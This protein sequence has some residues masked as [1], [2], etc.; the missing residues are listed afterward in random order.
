[1][2]RLLIS[3]GDRQFQ[4]IS[5]A[6]FATI[7]G[8][9][10]FD[11]VEIFCSDGAQS[12][13]LKT[14]WIRKLFFPLAVKFSG[15][16]LIFRCY[17]SRKLHFRS[18]FSDHLELLHYIANELLLIFN[19]AIA[20]KFRI[21]FYSDND[22]NVASNFIASILKMEKIKRSAKVE[23]EF[24]CL[25]KVKIPLEAITNWLVNSEEN[26]NK[27][28]HSE[29]FFEVKVGFREVKF[30]RIHVSFRFDRAE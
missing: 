5:N 10:R 21:H 26:G 30:K 27:R 14:E 12:I 18:D 20:F 2:A 9:I 13:G 19:S 3:T 15:S 8:F 25:Q 7:P 1:M 28:A 29:K 6:N 24:S 16:E 23:F 4:Q 17:I 11:A 22:E